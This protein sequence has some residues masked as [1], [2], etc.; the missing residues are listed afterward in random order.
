[1]FD[2]NK[3]GVVGSLSVWNGEIEPIGSLSE[4]W[5]SIQGI[6]PKW[7][8]WKSMAEVSSSLGRMVEVDWQTLFNTFFSTVR[9]KIQCKDPTKIPKERLFVFKDKIHLIMFT[10]EGFEQGEAPSDGG[11]DKGGGDDNKGNGPLEEDVSN[12]EN[13]GND[14]GKKEDKSKDKSQSASKDG[15]HKDTSSGTKNV[16]RSLL[17]QDEVLN[18]QLET[19][20]TL[21]CARLLSA[22]ELEEEEEEDLE[23]NMETDLEQLDEEDRESCHLPEQW[24]YDLSE[25]RVR[26]KGVYHKPD[27]VVIDLELSDKEEIATNSVLELTATEEEESINTQP[28][29]VQIETSTRDQQLQKKGVLELSAT[30]GEESINTQPSQVQIEAATGEQELQKKGAA[31]KK[32]K[33]G[34]VLPLRRSTRHLEDGKTMMDKAQEAKRKWN[35]DDNTG[36]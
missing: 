31:N 23:E 6:P 3:P 29:Q 19:C 27:A 25:E 24:V 5:V 34:P 26:N 1:M 7:V 11:S 21:A 10:P 12:T 9:V 20:S 15:S 4:V 2:M 13:G 22:M 30:E 17:F 32:A 16:R 8:D 28:S 33:W 35:L 36:N 14:G 18:Q